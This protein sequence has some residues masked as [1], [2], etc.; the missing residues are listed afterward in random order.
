MYKTIQ[1]YIENNDIKNGLLLLDLPTGSGKTH[2]VLDY[3]YDAVKNGCTKKFFF[4]TTL[5]KNL[6]REDMKNRYVRDGRDKE[7][8]EDVLF[9][10]SNYETV[11]STFTEA[12]E[13][14]IPLEIKN[15]EEYKEFQSYIKGIRAF[16]DKAYNNNN[17]NIK[18]SFEDQFRRFVEPT[19]RNMVEKLLAKQFKKRDDRLFAIKTDSNWQWLGELYPAV[20]TREKKIIFLSMDKFLAR[21]NTL[22]EPSYLFYN[23]DILDDAIVFIDEVDATKETILNN[24]IENGLDDK[25]DYLELFNKI[26]S[27]LENHTFPTMMTTASKKRKEGKYKEQSLLDILNKVSEIATSIYNDYKLQYSYKTIEDDDNVSN[28]NFLFQDHQYHSIGKHSWVTK[29]SDYTERINRIKFTS[30]QP[31]L[32]EDNVHTMLGRL[33][34]FITYFQNAIKILANNYCELRNEKRR[35][36]E[37]EYTLESAVR[38]ILE[39][40]NLDEDYISYLT[41]QILLSEKKKS[42]RI[43]DDD[44]DLTF[45]QNGFRYFAFE[46]SP[47]YDLHS[48]IMMYSFQVTPEKLLL[49]VCNKAKVV[50]ISATA[51]VPTNLGNFDIGYIKSSLGSNYVEVNTDD[52]NRMKNDFD[53]SVK[54]YDGNIEIHTKLINGEDNSEKAWA[55]LFNGNEELASS[56]YEKVEI[57]CA[58]AN[59]P[60]FYKER[61]FRIATAYKEFVVTKE[62]RS[63]LCV[64][65]FHPKP[66]R[67]LRDKLLLEEIFNSI[68]ASYD[69]QS[70]VYNCVRYL[71]GTDY[72]EKKDSVLSELSTGKELFVISVYQ[73]I[74]AGQNLQY[75][76]P[77]GLSD[78]LVKINNWDRSS[79]K[80]FDAIYLE[81]PTNL[82]V[83]LNNDNLEDKDFIKYIYQ[84]E[85]LQEN[86]ELS[87]VEALKN[88]KAAFTAYRTGKKQWRRSPDTKSIKLLSTKVLIQAIGRLCRTN[89]K[90][91]DIYIFAD[92][93]ISDYIDDSV[94]EGRLLNP[95]FV[96]LLC[97]D[98]CQVEV[99]L[100]E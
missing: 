2:N 77:Q 56:I 81:R 53:S 82:I 76:I 75:K 45:Y 19:F 93:H 6:P 59:T 28:Q 46:N 99:S 36:D 40:F 61:Y 98:L 60:D 87:F 17:F 1:K 68:A 89:M 54:G 30:E 57:D 47:D 58:S 67:Q 70:N 90:S 69:P 29:Y 95:E 14:K 39:E 52:F 73:T 37:D 100:K 15:T 41:I 26:Y 34:G 9:I 16:D 79:E 20:Y 97:N 44:F 35:K 86:Y 72:E 43:K 8:D 84:M 88:I 91:K 18:S 85:Y 27:A 25:I 24:L 50:G 11:L 63:M 3:I 96:R 13:Y 21:N 55:D 66:A 5:K 78:K 80:D 71:D 38:S 94:L 62:I 23:S 31:K 12:L 32:E 22:I 7:F 10:N 83:N 64:L 33:R 48:K 65:N 42:L 92:S 4:V 74:G 49:K 51:T